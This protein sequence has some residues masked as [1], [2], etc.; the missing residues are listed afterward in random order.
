M[1]LLLGASTFAAGCSRGNARVAVPATTTESVTVATTST[2]TTVDPTTTTTDLGAAATVEYR[3]FWDMFLQLGAMTGTFDPKP[4]IAILQQH[5]AGREYMLLFNNFQSDRAAG[6]VRKGTIDLA[7]KVVSADSSKA[8]I[9]DC[10]DDHI[11]VFK[12]VTGQRLDV[13][14]PARHPVTVSLVNDGTGWKVEFLKF[15]EGTCTV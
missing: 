11:G 1:A 12:A 8:T 14:T 5:T 6:I 9:T 2:S 13:D 15:E 3:Q 7:P 4:V 10:E